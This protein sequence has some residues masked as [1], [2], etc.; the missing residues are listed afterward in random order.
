MYGYVVPLKDKLSQADFGLYRAFYCGI[1]KA[2]G[3]RYGQL[4]RFTTSYDVTFL[5]VL[6]TDYIYGEA[7]F[8]NERCLLNPFRKKTVVVESELLSRIVALNVI[9]AYAKADDDVIDDGFKKRFARKMLKKAYRKAVKDLPQADEIVKKGYAD[10]R[11]IEKRNERSID[12]SSDCF[13]TILMELCKLLCADKT[14]EHIERLFYNVG[15]FVYLADALD[16][17]DEDCKKNR[18]NPLLAHFGLTEQTKKQRKQFVRKEFINNYR[19]QLEFIFATCINRAIE[20][21]NSIVFTGAYDLLKN[22]VYY[23]LRD[24]TMQLLNSEKKLPFPKI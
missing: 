19:P 9:L 6:I 3:R 13:A 17:V 24:K 20:C 12:V 22:V 5:S 10:L 23:G 2:T 4:P 11:E 18:Y 14:S 15:K 7:N 21:F 8:N 16:D 1:C